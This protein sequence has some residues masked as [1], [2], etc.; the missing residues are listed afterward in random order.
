MPM[1]CKQSQFYPNDPE[2][3]RTAIECHYFILDNDGCNPE[4]DNTQRRGLLFT[5]ALD[6]Q[7]Q[8]AAI[9]GTGLLDQAGLGYRLTVRSKKKK[10]GDVDDGPPGGFDVIIKPTEDNT[11][12]NEPEFSRKITRQKCPEVAK[13]ASG[14]G[15]GRKRRESKEEEASKRC[16]S[17]TDVKQNTF[18]PAPNVF[19]I[20]TWCFRFRDGQKMKTSIIKCSGG[21]PTVRVLDVSC[22]KFSLETGE[23]P[24]GGTGKDLKFKLPNENPW[25]P[26]CQDGYS[27][28]LKNQGSAYVVLVEEMTCPQARVQDP[29]PGAQL[30]EYLKEVTRGGGMKFYSW[31]NGQSVNDAYGRLDCSHTEP[32]DPAKLALTFKPLNPTLKTAKF[33]RADQ[34]DLSIT[35]ELANNSN[36]HYIM[37]V[38]QDQQWD[39]SSAKF[40]T[41]PRQEWEKN[42]RGWRKFVPNSQLDF[43][44]KAYVTVCGVSAGKK[45]LVCLSHD[46]C[47]INQRGGFLNACAGR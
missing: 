6:S 40:I 26:V 34:T 11:K 30:W 33:V 20:Y 13:R 44:T 32:A 2:A 47:C 37:K 16:D 17:V 8:R 42:E 9:M 5:Y 24:V 1:S 38:K 7:S 14:G 18:T 4:E 31:K 28:D 23:S 43:M 35:M 36:M 3:G 39:T 10:S 25:K 45:A 29:R 46:N 15:G 41:W 22:S 21:G 19:A 12:W 27:L